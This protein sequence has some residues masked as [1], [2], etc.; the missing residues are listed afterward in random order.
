MAT[1]THEDPEMSAAECENL[2][3]TDRVYRLQL[4]LQKAHRENIA[5][6][7]ELDDIRGAAA[8]FI[9]EARSIL[10]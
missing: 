2:V 6:R 10:D 7:K 5:L 4:L 1:E 3:L 9:S 8:E